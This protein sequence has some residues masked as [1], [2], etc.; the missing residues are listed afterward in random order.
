M[1]INKYNKEALK[2]KNL[3]EAR[4]ELNKMLDMEDQR[5]VLREIAALQIPELTFHSF[6]KL[7]DQVSEKDVPMLV[8]VLE[9]MKP[10]FFGGEEVVAFNRTVEDMIATLENKTNISRTPEEKTHP[11]KKEKYLNRVKDWVKKNKGK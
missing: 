4:K 5:D 3:A 6:N 11:F 10:P 2:G 1:D 8:E 9:T 7:K